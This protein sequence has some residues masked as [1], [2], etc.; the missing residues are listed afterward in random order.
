MD[1]GTQGISKDRL[2]AAGW[3]LETFGEFTGGL[4][5]KFLVL[6]AKVQSDDSF[7]TRGS[8]A[9]IATEQRRLNSPG[10]PTSD[11][12]D[13]CN[14]QTSRELEVTRPKGDWYKK[15]PEDLIACL[16]KYQQDNN[17]SLG[18]DGLRIQPG[19]Y[20]CPFCIESKRKLY[21]RPSHFSNHLASHWAALKKH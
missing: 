17:L 19:N 20:V 7:H 5:V 2:A 9:S 16:E 21:K 18:I 6:H 4:Q 8:S 15:L 13:G 3:K 12:H 11:S 14:A 1:P 10:A